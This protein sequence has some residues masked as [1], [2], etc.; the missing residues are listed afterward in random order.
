MSFSIVCPKCN[1]NKVVANVNLE[2][3]TGFIAIRVNKDSISANV[4]KLIANRVKFSLD[5]L[6]CSECKTSISEKDIIFKC[7]DSGRIGPVED[8]VLLKIVGH[9]KR[10]HTIIVH[11]SIAD[12]AE[13][14]HKSVGF[15]VTRLIPTFKLK[16]SLNDKKS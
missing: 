8:F 6:I 13:E 4:N 2:N 10:S 14:K 3:L 1:S 7:P 16:E 12:R 5:N 15:T 9:D 11:K